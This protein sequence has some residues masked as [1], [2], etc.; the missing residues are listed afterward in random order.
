MKSFVGSKYYFMLEI[1]SLFVTC[2]CW[3]WGLFHCSWLRQWCVCVGGGGLRMRDRL[4]SLERRHPAVAYLPWPSP[5]QRIMR[6]NFP[7]PSSTRF[8]VYLEQI[9]GLSIDIWQNFSRCADE[10]D[11]KGGLGGEKSQCWHD[12]IHK[13]WVVTRGNRQPWGTAGIWWSSQF[14]QINTSKQMIIIIQK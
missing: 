10:Q 11:K 6:L 8:L 5:Q 3:C 4:S 14:I 12:Y 9:C 1:M 7:L 13:C 2:C